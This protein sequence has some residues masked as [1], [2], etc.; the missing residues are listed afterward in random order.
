MDVLRLLIADGNDDFRTALAEALQGQ[1]YVR[2][3]ATGREALEQLR[4][5]GP[6]ILVLNLLL[7]EI[8]GITLL[9]QAVREQIRPMVL[10]TTRY[11]NDYI[12]EAVTRL[13]VGYVMMRPCEIPA[14]VARIRDLSRRLDPPLFSAPDPHTQV[15][16]LL[17]TLGIPTRLKGYQQAKEAILRMAADPDQ[18]ITKEL[19]PAVAA[20][21]GGDWR[22]VERTIRSAIAAAWKKRDERIWQHYFPP[23]PDGTVRK[24]TNGDFITR[25]A[26]ALR[27]NQAGPDSDT[28]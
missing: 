15:T 4:S 14:A 22:H 10:V 28:H 25:M 12:M 8:D 17:L 16:N 6:D 19:Y 1:Y 13:G 9:E 3:C 7:P 24:P 21:C 20:V 18:S 2:T 23:E 5:Y 11:Q 27:L 26:E